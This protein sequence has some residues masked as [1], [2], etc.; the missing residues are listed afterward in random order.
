[1]LEKAI[2]EYLRTYLAEGRKKSV[3][4]LGLNALPTPFPMCSAFVT[5][6]R[7]GKVIASSGRFMPKLPNAVLETLDSALLALQDARLQSSPLSAADLDA[8]RIRIDILDQK[9][10][11]MLQG[12]EGFNPKTE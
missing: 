12:L 9:A 7:S 10:R 8:V 11:R 5:L 2:R 4:E 6:Y 1:M 3:E